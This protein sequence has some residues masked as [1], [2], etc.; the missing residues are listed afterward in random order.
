[1]TLQQLLSPTR[2]AVDEYGM[3]REGDKVAVGL[4]GGKDSVTLL[5][6][7]AG[8]KR[9]YPQ[10]FDL[11][12]ITV[13]MG[14]KETDEKEKQAMHDLCAELGVPYHVEK[15]DIAEIIFDA[16][17]ET[18]PCSLCAK[19]RR[20]ALNSVA[21]SLGCNKL[22]LGHHADDLIET[23]FLSMFYEG[24]LSTFAPVSYMDRT[25]MTLIRP[26]IYVEEKDIAAFAKDKPILHNPCPA[27]KHT[28]REYVKKLIADIKKDIPF[29]KRRIHGA[30]THPERYNLFDKCERFKI[31]IVKDNTVK[32][33]D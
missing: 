14:F 31:E 23:L 24:R 8:L 33:E 2:R 29:V 28:Q 3:I 16:R 30:I 9:F 5:Y 18:N 11:I 21:V 10:N 26:M 1:M 15:T 19:M 22:A 25:G 17:K 27:D 12:A 7:L 20:G 4:S 13:D 6:A 32:K